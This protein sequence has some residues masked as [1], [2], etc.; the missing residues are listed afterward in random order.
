MQLRYKWLHLSYDVQNQIIA[1]FCAVL[2]LLVWVLTAACSADEDD[3]TVEIEDGV[4]IDC[5]EDATEIIIPATYDG[6][7]VTE[8]GEAAFQDC[9]ALTELSISADLVT[10]GDEAFQNCSALTELTLPD[11]VTT[12]GAEAFSGCTSLASLTLSEDLTTIGTRAFEDCTALTELTMPSNV[13]SMENVSLYTCEN[14]TTLYYAGTEEE[15]DALDAASSY[16]LLPDDCE[17]V[18]LEEEETTTE[19]PIE[20]ETTTEAILS[21]WDLYESYLVDTYS[22][23]VTYI[24]TTS[25]N[26]W[27]FHD[28][29]CSTGLNATHKEYYTGPRDLLIE[30]GCDPAGCCEP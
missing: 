24:V 30:L 26:S 7:D 18:F 9:D 16:I 5:D 6:E 23:D 4:V 12:I 28:T 13:T 25:G 14:L 19:E 15:W 27:K 29:D 10:I 2:A 22:D 21:D 3:P 20:E 11:S 1:V 8:I 17:V